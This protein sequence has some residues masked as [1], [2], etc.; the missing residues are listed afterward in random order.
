MNA[1]R[2]RSLATLAAAGA[3]LACVAPA[4]AAPA[5]PAA[6]AQP[7]VTYVTTC[8]GDSVRAPKTFALSCENDSFV[9]KDLRW[10]NWGS[11]TATAV[12]TAMYGGCELEC[13]T[14][15]GK[16]YT[17]RV[18]VTRPENGESAIHYTRMVTRLT[19]HGKPVVH[20][21]NLSSDQGPTIRS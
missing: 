15:D 2:R 5:A 17:V 20:A 1:P 7:D 21:W 13:A 18:T 14:K 9:M 4:V 8:D 11:R 16:K 3:A 6:P 19:G 12:G 10:K